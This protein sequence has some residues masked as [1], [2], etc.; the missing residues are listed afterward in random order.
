MFWETLG[1]GIDL[2]LTL[3]CTIQTE[4]TPSW[5]QR[6]KICSELARGT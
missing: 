1:L 4:P 5:Q 6:R 3:T 2:D